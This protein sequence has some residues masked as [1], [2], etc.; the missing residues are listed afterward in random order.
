MEYREEWRF[1]RRDGS[2][3]PGDVIATVM[4]DGNLLAVVRDITEH[5]RA[6]DALARSERDLRAVAEELAIERA[7]LV[8]AQSV[9]R[10]GSWDT[11]L[12]TREVALSA[13]THRIFETDAATFVG[14]HEGSS[15]SCTPPI[16]PWRPARSS[17]RSRAARRPRSSTGC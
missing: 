6:G 5:K 9:A 10:I 8:E 1:R 12:L 7:H 13:E 17:S 4:P 16:A 14:T 2:E 15:R 11:N 3:F